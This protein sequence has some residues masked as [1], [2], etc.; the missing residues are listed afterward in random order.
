[1]AVWCGLT[2]HEFGHEPTPKELLQGLDDAYRRELQRRGWE[3]PQLHGSASAPPAD[4]AT[5]ATRYGPVEISWAAR[6]AL[7]E[8]IRRRG[9]SDFVAR[10]FEAVGA[11]RPVSLDRDGKIV[12][13]DALWA[14]AENAGGYDLIDP[15]LRELRDRLKDEIAEAP[16]GERRR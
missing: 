12:V 6:D 10:V 16:G 15:Q 4:S 5:I 8:E 11:S 2:S 14:M 3:Y 1:V 7:L 13:F 9:S